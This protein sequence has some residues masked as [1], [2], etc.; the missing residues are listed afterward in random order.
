MDF[1]QPVYSYKRTMNKESLIYLIW[2]VLIVVWNFGYPG[3]LPIYDVMVAVILSI[4]VKI[5]NNYRKQSK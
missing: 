2:L 5:L 4:V 3:A 1:W